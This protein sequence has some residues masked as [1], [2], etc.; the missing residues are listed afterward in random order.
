MAELQ[1]RVCSEADMCDISS[2]YY[3]ISR[4][5]LVHH[6]WE[7]SA[8]AVHG[9]FMCAQWAKVQRYMCL[10][11]ISEPLSSKQKQKGIYMSMWA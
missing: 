11:P 2:S 6:F 3:I 4:L 10:Q 5:C 9:A 7:H 1:A 8:T